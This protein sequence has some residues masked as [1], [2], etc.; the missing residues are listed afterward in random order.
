MPA[1]K[2]LEVLRSVTGLLEG[3][4]RRSCSPSLS[5]RVA[6][7]MVPVLAGFLIPLA[8]AELAPAEAA[9]AIPVELL[10]DYQGATD[11]FPFPGYDDAYSYVYENPN[12]D[13]DDIWT[14][15]LWYYDFGLASSYYRPSFGST[16][17]Y[18]LFI[19]NDFAHRYYLGITDQANY[20]LN[21]SQ[22]TFNLLGANFLADQGYGLEVDP[23]NPTHPSSWPE[24]YQWLYCWERDCSAY[25]VLGPGLDALFTPHPDL[26]SY[27]LLQ[28]LLNPTSNYGPHDASI[29]LADAIYGIIGPM[30]QFGETVGLNFGPIG[31]IFSAGEMLSLATEFASHWDGYLAGDP[32]DATHVWIQMPQ[33]LFSGAALVT[34]GIPA[35][36][37]AGTAF[38][39]F[40]TA[41]GALDTLVTNW[42]G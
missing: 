15:F 28:S 21:P 27:D 8:C 22:L 39:V 36:E 20:P 40:G 33:F 9:S 12:L 18:Y 41:L 5:P 29:F 14:A 7:A 16:A 13:A 31:E 25:G 2:D 17:E 38:G 1:R 32:L 24:Y 4:F 11:P 10:N 35:L 30:L 34:Q 6:V 26:S 19:Q 3:K 42:W 37:V 23:E